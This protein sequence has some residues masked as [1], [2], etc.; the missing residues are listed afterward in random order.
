MQTPRRRI[1][2]ALTGASGVAYFLRTLERL[3]AFPELEL[4]LVASEGG[5]RV[6]HDEENMKWGDINTEGCVVHGTRNIGASIASGSNGLESLVVVPCSMSSLSAMAI[7]MAENLVHRAAAVQLKEGRTL[8]VVPRETPLSL[9]SLRAMV[10]LREAGAVIMPASPGFYHQPQTV[11]D[12]VD[13]VVDRIIDHLEV[14]DQAV[15]RWNPTPT[16]PPN[17]QA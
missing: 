10:T 3:R 14:A 13:S 15:R 2:L 17:P 7:G 12:L 11:T 16:G 9:I 6:L 4:H 5:K 8:I 1:G